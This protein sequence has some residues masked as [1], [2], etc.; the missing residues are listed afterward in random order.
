MRKLDQQKVAG[1]IALLSTLLKSKH[2][3]IASVQKDVDRYMLLD[4][5]SEAKALMQSL[6]E[7]REEI[8]TLEEELLKLNNITSENESAHTE[9]FLEL[10]A[11]ATRMGKRL[12]GKKRAADEVDLSCTSNESNEEEDEDD[13]EMINASDNN[14]PN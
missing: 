10:G 12:S 5:K 13:V 6:S 14:T 8:A 11:A 9:Q 2:D 1:R 7:K 3:G 4:M